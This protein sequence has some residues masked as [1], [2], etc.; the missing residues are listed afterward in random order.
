MRQ[1]HLRF[2]SP[3]K[4]A[5][6]GGFAAAA[7]V[8]GAAA[9]LPGLVPGRASAAPAL[10]RSRGEGTVTSHHFGSGGGV[11]G[12]AASAALPVPDSGR[13]MTTVA[14]ASGA[15][16]RGAAVVSGTWGTAQEVPGTASLNAGGFA[17][18]TSV[19]CATAGNCGA[20]GYYVD[21]AGDL[22]TFVATETNGVW[23]TAEKVPGLTSLNGGGVPTAVSVSCAAAGNCTAGGS[24]EDGSGH[25]QAFVVTEANGTWGKAKQVPGTA[26]LNA[27]GFAAVKSVSCGAA[28]DCSAGGDY[29]DSAGHYQAFVVTQASGVWGKAKEVPGTAALNAGGSAGVNSMSCAAAGDC[30][31]GGIYWD[32]AGN[33]QAFVVTQASGIWGKAKEVPGTATL[34]AGGRA[35][36]SSVSC[37]SA[38][39]CSA[40]GSYDDS[41]GATQ[42]FVV[43]Q[44]NGIWGKAKEV[45]GTAALNVGLD[46]AV[47]SVSC[48]SAGNCSAG[49]NYQGGPS[50]NQ[51]F[52]V[53]QAN[54]IWGK[55]EEVPG[56]AALNVGGDA[57]VSS[58]SCAT[59]GNC[60]AGGF[61]L[62][63][64]GGSG[65][66]QAFVVTR[67][68][69]IWGT[70]QEV[71][72]MASLA[73][74]GGKIT[75]VSCAAANRC[76]AGG[77]Y[78]DS[79]DNLQAFV[80]TES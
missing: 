54:G 17:A 78:G 14:R 43:T 40:G 61:Y 48:A 8:A 36:V 3:R 10:T 59:A 2:G 33:F 19:S 28:G 39:N 46:A 6:R 56:T 41:G 15:A 32:G 63:G 45:P 79:A 76:S 21:G 1:G 5:R 13:R 69:G 37:A 9:V 23:G 58:V 73:P 11:A 68:N 70:A 22:Q 51:A 30:S 47:N 50:G 57:A 20:A 16:G 74:F 29:T 12:R 42:A 31:A 60:S 4:H 25:F 18:V 55:A 71:S 44:A 49:G 52:V 72:G 64:S 62:T 77:Q 26:A 80:V 7:V 53:T 67:V 38:G 65:N 34:N 35:A 66:L 24:Y 27:G 75:S